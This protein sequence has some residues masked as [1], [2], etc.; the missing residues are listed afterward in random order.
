VAGPGRA[1]EVYREGIAFGDRRGIVF[2][3]RWLEAET[4]W[5]LYDLG[6][7]DELLDVADRMIDWDKAY[8]GSQ[9]GLIALSYKTYVLAQR[10]Q[11]RDAQS[12]C[13]E[14]LVRA[15]ESGDEQVLA[16]SITIAALT[17]LAAGDTAAATGYVLE[18]AEFGESGYWPVTL[19]DTVRVASSIGDLAVARSLLRE[20][21]GLT[22]RGKHVLVTARA[23]VAEAR[24]EFERALELHEQARERWE[25]FGNVVERAHALAGAGRC[26]TALGRGQDAAARLE[27]A[28]EVYTSLRARPL[29]AEVAA[30]LEPVA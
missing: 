20:T 25:A 8:G 3:A 29:I 17:S 30:A 12:L 10:G 28:R 22:P 11:L 23:V 24:R 19:A 21:A 27:A 4:V 2:K 14:L 9:V 5:P 18:F 16:P 15:R 1:L 6:R 26:L 13:D 7:W